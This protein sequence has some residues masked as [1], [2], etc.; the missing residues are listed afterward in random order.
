MIREIRLGDSDG[1]FWR[2]R[3]VKHPRER[4]EMNAK[5]IRPSEDPLQVF[6][7]SRQDPKDEEMFRAR[8]L[9]IEEVDRFPV[10]KAWAFEDAPASSEAARDRYVR[11]AGRADVVIWLIGSTTT[12]PIVEEIGA[13]MRARGKLLAFMIPAN[14][15]DDETE[16]LIRRVSNYATWK[17]VEH[18]DDLPDHIRASLT[19]EILQRHRDPAPVNHDLYLRQKLRESISDT[20]R[21]WATLGVPED[22]AGELAEDHSVGHKLTIPTTGTLTVNAR[23][24]S[25]KTLAAHRLFQLALQHRLHDHFQ[26]L[27]VFLNARNISGDLKDHIEGYIREHGPVYTQRVLVI[28]DGLDETGRSKANQLLNQAQSYTD[29][30]GNVSAVVI[31]RPLPGL[32][33]TAEEYTLPQCSEEEFLSIASRVAGRDVRQSEIPFREYRTR[34]PLFA[35]IV[36]AYLRQPM[37]KWGRAPSQMVSEMVRQALG[38]SLDDLGDAAELLKTLAVASISS[39]ESVDKT[40]VATKTSDQVRVAN[41]RIVVEEDGKFDFTL[42]IFREWFAARA[43]VERSI[44]FEE[45]ELKSDRWVVPLAIAINSENPNTGREIM[46]RLASSDPGMAGLVLDEVK[47]NWSHNWSEEEH[48]K[49]FPSGTAIEIGTSIRKAMEDWNDGLGPLMPALGMQAKAGGI[50]TLGIEVRSGWVTTSWYGGDEELPPVVQ[51]PKDLLDR[52]DR[53]YEGWPSLTSRGIESTRVW[54]WSITH[55]ELSR[56]LSEQLKSFSLALEFTVGFHEFAYEFTSHL[57]GAD[58][59]ARDIGTPTD[60]I[61][62]IDQWIRHLQGDPRS[63]VTFG[64]SGYSFTVPELELFKERVSDHVGK[65]TDILVDPWPQPD[66]EWPPGRTGGMWFERYTEERL[67][68]RTNA[69]FNGALEIYNLIVERWLPAFNRRNQM[70]YMLPFRMSGELRLRESSKPND[71]KEAAL[72][73]W[74]EWVDDAVDSGVFI[75]MGGKGRTFD[76]KTRKRIQAAQERFAEQGKPHYSGWGVLHG[77]EPRPA[78]TLA[79]EWLT[80]DLRTLH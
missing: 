17:T 19:D 32:S 61:D 21:L 37:P 1:Y 48:S 25:G 4:R 76:D 64:R 23:Q 41:S 78:T 12:T 70:T 72:I 74:S 55:D 52:Y 2:G 65:G 63:S 71:R 40:L 69:I 24:G 35:T 54:P 15:R 20:R 44:S 33:L 27:P 7:S 18:V 67:L 60:L 79:H 30:N 26:P 49:S 58:F 47:H 14:E 8:S 50:P 22:I 59:E 9:A 11:N 53:H 56:S 29:A 16:A 57:R 31:T 77:Y 73:H 51:L 80:H 28:I 34:L 38:D 39:G 43:I 68:Q 66:K 36:G 45:I 10:T 6:I 3:T 42:A 62:Y 5:Q 13:C 75:E 46:E